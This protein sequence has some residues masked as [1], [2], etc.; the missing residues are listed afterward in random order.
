MAERDDKSDGLIS[1]PRQKYG[2]NFQ[3]HLLEQYKLYVQSAQDISE[4][5]LSANNYLLTLCS[6]IVT[7]YGVSLSSFGQR[8]WHVVLPITGLLVCYVWHSLVESY[9]SLNTA[10]FKV[11]H[12]LER[13]LPVALFRYEWKVCDFGKTEKYVPLTHLERYVPILFA[14]FFFVLVL[15]SMFG[16]VT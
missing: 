4:R 10:K 6:S 5:R 14:I 8:R 15:Y 7:L 9:K 11:I 2:E 13:E 3:E 12:E 16:R 1:Q